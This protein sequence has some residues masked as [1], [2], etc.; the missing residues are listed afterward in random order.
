M[1][2]ER[3]TLGAPAD[4]GGAPGST[5]GNVA[6]DKVLTRLESTE[7]PTFTA[8]YGVT[9]K[10]DPNSTDAVVAQDG[11]AT[12]ITLGD[13]R[14]LRRDSDQ[15]CSISEQRCE[16]GI[17]EARISDYSIGSGFYASSPARA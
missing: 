7:H 8:T 9:R 3:P 4:I 10:L 12:S 2:G 11:A 16:D 15:T 6:V 1:T 17:L 14:F 13:V 5:T